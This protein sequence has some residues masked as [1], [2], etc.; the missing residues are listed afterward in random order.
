MNKIKKLFEKI[1]NFFSGD[2]LD[3][4][5]KKYVDMGVIDFSGEGR[6]KYGKWMNAKWLQETISTRTDA[7]MV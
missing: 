4:M 6:N 7:Y 5:I 3:R 1:R 2:P